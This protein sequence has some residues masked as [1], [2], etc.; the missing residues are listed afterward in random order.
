ML[1]E[2]IQIHVDHDM[3]ANYKALLLAIVR[4]EYVSP[5][6]AIAAVW[7]PLNPFYEHKKQRQH[8]PK[9]SDEQ[10]MYVAQEHINGRTW[11]SIGDEFGLTAGGIYDAWRRWKAR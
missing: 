1:A 6:T 5:D 7:R 2:Q 3:S 11:Q 9:Y 8:T 4:D 10:M